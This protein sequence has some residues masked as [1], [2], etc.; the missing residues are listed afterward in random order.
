MV[1]QFRF[2]AGHFRFFRQL[3]ENVKS[4]QIVSCHIMRAYLLHDM[5]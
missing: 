2:S 4:Y 3:P 1:G 5:L